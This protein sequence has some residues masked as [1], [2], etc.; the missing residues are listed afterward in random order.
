MS[1]DAAP[2]LATLDALNEIEPS[3][4]VRLQLLGARSSVG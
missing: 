3:H 2:F 4:I 1:D